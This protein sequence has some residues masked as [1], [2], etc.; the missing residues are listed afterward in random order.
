[1][2]F[3]KCRMIK[4]LEVQVVAKK[5]TELIHTLVEWRQNFFIMSLGP[6]NS[7]SVK[8]K[9]AQTRLLRRS[10]ALLQGGIS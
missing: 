3:T 9:R 2:I 4:I 10:A 8:P 7:E 1:M 5:T 6:G